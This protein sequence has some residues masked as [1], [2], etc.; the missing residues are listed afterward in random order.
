[1]KDVRMIL[2]NPASDTAGAAAML[3]QLG[4]LS[5]IHD[6]AGSMESYITFDEARE[7]NGK[8]TVA[9][10]L[11]RLEA[12]TGD[13][14]ILLN[15]IET[16][17]ADNPPPFT[18]I[19]GSPVPFVI[20]TDLDGIAA[21]A[22]FITN[23]PAF[24]VNTGGFALYDKGAGEA[25]KKVLAKT[26]K[27]PVEHTGHI[28]NLLG[29]SP[30]DYSPAEIEDITQMLLQNG[31]DTVRNLTM[32]DGMEQ[33]YSAAE[34]DYN[35]VISTS[36]LSAARFMKQKYDIPYQIGIPFANG[37]DLKPAT[38]K[39]VLL[40]GESVFTKQL[41]YILSQIANLEV[42]A[43]IISSDDPEIFPEVTTVSLYTVDSI[44]TEVRKDYD[45]IFGDPL[46][47]LLLP[48]NHNCM[49]LSRP[50]RALSGRLYPFNEYKFTKYF[51]ELK[52]CF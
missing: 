52:G 35:I 29:A 24:A 15:K 2:P 19:L 48:Q 14:S 16:E 32:H 5:I 23:V 9:S 13:D 26:V 41:A 4:G 21:E 7:L 22:E 25:L 10:R 3:F 38:P 28:V 39:K 8:R 11:S 45:I 1:M 12:I 50:H 42:V 33:I 43:G 6:A 40:I 44:R 49:F 30:M 51:E 34:A 31:V 27:P 18:A 17:C 20:G 47:K 36:G 46:Y 37:I